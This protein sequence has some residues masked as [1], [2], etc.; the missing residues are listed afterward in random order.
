MSNTTIPSI[1]ERVDEFVLKCR[2]EGLKVTPQRIAVF[3]ALAESDRHPSAE[4]IH[5]RIVQDMPT[6][7][8]DTVY[9]TL[10]TLMEHG[11]IRRVDSLPNIGRFDSNVD[12]HHHFVCTQCNS[13]QDFYWPDFDQLQP[14]SEVAKMG[15]IQQPYVEFRGLC[16]KCQQERMKAETGKDEG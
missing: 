1:A 15:M 2:E 6:V 10:T 8:L 3:R 12:H 13:I 16:R 14:P 11:V 5:Q 4:E 9:R 7:S